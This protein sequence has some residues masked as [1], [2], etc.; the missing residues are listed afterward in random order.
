MTCVYT[1]TQLW[2]PNS[3]QHNHILSS[4]PFLFSS[5]FFPSF[6]H[7]SAFHAIQPDQS[8]IQTLLLMI[9]KNLQEQTQALMNSQSRQNCLRLKHFN[10]FWKLFFSS[11]LNTLNVTANKLL[12]SQSRPAN[13]L[14]TSQSRLQLASNKSHAVLSSPRMSTSTHTWLTS[15]MGSI[16]SL[17]QL[18]NPTCL[19]LWKSS[20]S[21]VGSDTKLKA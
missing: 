4:I 20:N 14:L 17:V 3:K 2:P 6:S 7:S 18:H 5:L 12:T 9:R 15:A 13:K 21:C 10:S 16:Q 11:E 19:L 1:R 8:S